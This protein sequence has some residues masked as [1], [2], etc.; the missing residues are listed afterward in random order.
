MG[1][2]LI[3]YFDDRL[4]M[5][6]SQTLATEHFQVA[7]MLLKSLGFIVNKCM[8]YPTQQIEFFGLQYR[9][10]HYDTILTNPDIVIF[11]E[12]LKTHHKPGRGAW[13]VI[14]LL[15]HQL[16]ICAKRSEKI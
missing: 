15:L 11:N 3:I 12:L 7:V 9:L 1:M 10:V 14:S 5:A 6:K 8:A 13:V 2:R 16:Q 4:L